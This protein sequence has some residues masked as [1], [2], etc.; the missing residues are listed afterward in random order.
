MFILEILQVIAI[1]F[2]FD[3][4]RTFASFFWSYTLCRGPNKSPFKIP[5]NIGDMAFTN[6]KSLLL[7]YDKGGNFNVM[8]IWVIAMN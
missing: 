5:K 2:S 6:S 1:H 4:I 7:F 3:M 8:Q